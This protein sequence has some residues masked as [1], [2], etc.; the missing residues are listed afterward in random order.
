V[1]EVIQPKEHK[2]LGREKL[3]SEERSKSSKRGNQ[4]LSMGPGVWKKNAQ[5]W[6]EG[7]AKKKK[8]GRAELK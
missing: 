8:K 6:S 5:L 2:D 3:G 7:N 1:R 4:R